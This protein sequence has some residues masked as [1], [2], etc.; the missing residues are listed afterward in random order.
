M[1]PQYCELYTVII[2][3]KKYSL[4]RYNI[5][6]MKAL[7]ILIFLLVCCTAAYAQVRPQTD[8]GRQN[9]RAAER[10]EQ[11]AESFFLQFRERKSGALVEVERSVVEARFQEM[12]DAI[13][14]QYHTPPAMRDS[15]LISR[16]QSAVELPGKLTQGALK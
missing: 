2:K 11:R 8:E 5:L 16:G 12:I 3:I 14:L 7:K 6:A 13:D 9:E 10:I 1:K 4:I 15:I